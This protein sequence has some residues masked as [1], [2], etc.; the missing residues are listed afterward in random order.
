MMI[1]EPVREWL[2]ASYCPERRDSSSSV[3]YAGEVPVGINL[4]RSRRMNT[5]H[6]SFDQKP[7]HAGTLRLRP[8]PSVGARLATGTLQGGARASPVSDLEEEAAERVSRTLTRMERAPP[9]A[10]RDGEKER[11]RAVAGPFSKHYDVA[12]RHGAKS[13]KDIF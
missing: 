12:I 3:T 2:Q 9:G 13:G 1:Y 6:V 11:W 5:D 7:R 4:S 10:D 8:S